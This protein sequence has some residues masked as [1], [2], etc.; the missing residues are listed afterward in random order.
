MTGGSGITK[1]TF[2]ETVWNERN[3]NRNAWIPFASG[4][5]VFS[6]LWT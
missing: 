4:R 3:R 5:H 1:K 6:G 2:I